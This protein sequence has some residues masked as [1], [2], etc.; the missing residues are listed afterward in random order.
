[1]NST[2]ESTFSFYKGS[3]LINKISD[4]QSCSQYQY[5]HS[6]RPVHSWHAD[7]ETQQKHK[8]RPFDH[9]QTTRY[10]NKTSLCIYP[11]PIRL[12]MILPALTLHSSPLPHTHCHLS[13]HNPLSRH[14][15]QSN[16]VLSPKISTVP[17]IPSIPFHC[18]TNSQSE[19]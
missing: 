15:I 13:C 12:Q 3:M 19:S 18:D 11:F 4:E 5:I 17:P 10:S 6:L 1:M 16:I 14:I 2:G 8:S 9:T 7:T